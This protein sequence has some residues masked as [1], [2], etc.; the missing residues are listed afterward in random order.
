MHAALG[1]QIFG[2][3]RFVQGKPCLN[4][5]IVSFSYEKGRAVPGRN[6]ERLIQFTCSAAFGSERSSILPLAGVDLD[7]I[8]IHHINLICT[9]HQGNRFL[10][11]CIQVL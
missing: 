6:G 9:H 4:S 2:G 8:G 5:F 7:L 10:Q 3:S 11:P 1:K